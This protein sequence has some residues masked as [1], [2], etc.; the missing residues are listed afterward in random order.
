MAETLQQLLALVD[1]EHGR[2]SYG[3]GEERLRELLLNLRNRVKPLIQLAEDARR[4]HRW[5]NYSGGGMCP[6]AYLH[7]HEDEMAVCDCGAD[8]WNARIDEVLK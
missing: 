6:K 1:Q 8:E 5:D 4:E 2:W 3:H 7:I